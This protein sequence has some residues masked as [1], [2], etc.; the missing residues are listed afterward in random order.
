[1]MHRGVAL[2]RREYPCLPE[3]DAKD[4]VEWAYSALH[5][6]EQHSRDI[7]DF[8][9]G[10]APMQDRALTY[11]P[12]PERSLCFIQTMR[13]SCD[14]AVIRAADEVGV[15]HKYVRRKLRNYVKKFAMG[16]GLRLAQCAFL[17]ANFKGVSA[18]SAFGNMVRVWLPKRM[19]P[20]EGYEPIFVSAL[21]EMLETTDW[22]NQLS[23]QGREQCETMF[24][25]YA[26]NAVS[27]FYIMVGAEEQGRQ[28]DEDVLRAMLRRYLETRGSG[29]KTVEEVSDRLNWIMSEYEELPPET[30][31]NEYG[32]VTIEHVPEDFR[33]MAR[34]C[35][36]L[37]EALDR[38]PQF[39]EE[40]IS[41]R[42]GSPITD[43][44]KQVFAGDYDA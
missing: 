23:A 19:P 9:A 43:M 8:V 20:K 13:D 2:L 3:R 41:L 15:T 18:D 6:A 42:S 37:R 7:T 22:R 34:H 10:A 5:E 33:L 35:G 25:E 21:N 1:M 14:A 27:S 44:L 29:L 31:S 40:V 32:Q 16:T 38:F 11:C 12:T 39:A 30:Y 4:A 17:R 28:G 26:E 36:A 24:R